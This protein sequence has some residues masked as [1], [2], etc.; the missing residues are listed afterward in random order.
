[1]NRRPAST[2]PGKAWGLPRPRN[3]R[4]LW[5]AEIRVPGGVGGAAGAP[6]LPVAAGRGSPLAGFV[7]R[8]CP[9]RP[10]PSWKRGKWISRFAGCSGILRS[11]AGGSPAAGVAGLGG[12]SW[13][14]AH[15]GGLQLPYP[16]T[17]PLLSP[18]FTAKQLEKLAKK[19]EKDSK[20]EQ[21]KVKKVG[22]SSP[23]M[24]RLWVLP[25][26]VPCQA[27]SPKGPGKGAGSPTQASLRASAWPLSVSSPTLGSQMCQMGVLHPCDAERVVT[28]VS[29]LRVMEE[30]F[31]AGN[32][33]S[34]NRARFF[35]N[36]GCTH[37]P[38][39]LLGSSAEECGV[40]SCLRGERHPQEE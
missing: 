37:C 27:C 20:A 26:A 40:R 8:V 16:G 13:G 19:A 33:S 18:Q 11:S 39:A 15:P 1:M 10:S 14:S 23:C 30:L 5:P 34:R 3:R 31:P 12:G 36:L 32:L 21:A 25:P 2:S 9:S 35:I 7:L 38:F 24:G 4:R 17:N 22:G 6:P 29:V 28:P